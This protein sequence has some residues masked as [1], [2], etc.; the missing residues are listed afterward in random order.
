MSTGKGKNMHGPA[1]IGIDIN[2]AHALMDSILKIIKSDVK[3]QKDSA[4]L[5]KQYKKAEARKAAEAPA[6]AKA[7]TIQFLKMV[8]RI[9]DGYPEI[10]SFTLVRSDQPHDRNPDL[11]AIE[12][13]PGYVYRGED[14]VLKRY[15]H[16]PF[17]I[18]MWAGSINDFPEQHKL[19]Y[20]NYAI[21]DPLMAQYSARAR[22]FIA[23]Q[24]L[25]K[26]SDQCKIERQESQS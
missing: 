19:L 24:Q 25:Q 4:R 12:F 20:K 15:M 14:P 23:L 5:A 21:S 7:Q 3:L 17:R 1:N 26:I 22:A 6:R 18:A 8:G 2:D 16:I 13:V 11:Q 10:Q 9:F